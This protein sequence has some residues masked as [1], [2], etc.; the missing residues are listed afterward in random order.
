MTHLPI[1]AAID[2]YTGYVWGVS[3]NLPA[4]LSDDT[5]A[6]VAG[7][8]ILSAADGSREYVVKACGRYDAGA[9][10]HLYEIPDTLDITDGQDAAQIAAVESGRYVG[11]VRVVPPDAD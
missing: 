4:N 10:L 5:A 9:S 7:R 3:E 6:E 1:L 2:H 11:S 8:Q